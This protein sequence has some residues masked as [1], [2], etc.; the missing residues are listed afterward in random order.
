V[1]N[2]SSVIEGA[3]LTN[4][5]PYHI[6]RK[7]LE[8]YIDKLEKCQC[9]PFHPFATHLSTGIRERCTLMEAWI[10]PLSIFHSVITAVIDHV[11]GRICARG[12]VLSRAGPP[13]LSARSGAAS[14]ERAGPQD[15][16]SGCPEVG[17]P[18]DPAGPH[19][20]RVLWPIRRTAEELC[21]KRAGTRHAPAVTSRP[22][23]RTQ[24][25]GSGVP[26]LSQNR[27]SL[28][29]KGPTCIG[30]VSIQ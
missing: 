22:L 23:G 25:I 15:H 1:A 28:S 16:P 29:Q 17:R 10:H 8:G 18:S 4:C 11:P 7:R 21:P 26:G 19:R 27:P 2:L 3:S 24:R 20:G 9:G 12:E 6:S 14:W 5:P 13:G 30:Q